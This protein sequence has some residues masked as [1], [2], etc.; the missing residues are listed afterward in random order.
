MPSR[1][2]LGWFRSVSMVRYLPTAGAA[3]SRTWV[4]LGVATGLPYLRSRSISR[5][6]LSATDMWVFCA[7]ALGALLAVF[8]VVWCWP[9]RIPKGRTV[10][11]IRQRIEDEEDD[12]L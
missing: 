10:E 3:A 9:S 12:E 11:E 6:H 5:R 4:G 7:V 1:R 8:V 2:Q